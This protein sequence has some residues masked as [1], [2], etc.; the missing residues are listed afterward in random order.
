MRSMLTVGTEL[1]LMCLFLF[2]QQC[3]TFVGYAK[4][5]VTTIQLLIGISCSMEQLRSWWVLHSKLGL[6]DLLLRYL[7]LC[8]CSFVQH[9]LS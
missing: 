9:V 3:I 2:P 4:I 8:A 5:P 6:Y 7:R 1:S